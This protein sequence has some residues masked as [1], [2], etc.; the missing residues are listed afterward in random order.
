MC[1]KDKCR[2][3]FWSIGKGIL[4]RYGLTH[5]LTII[6][7]QAIRIFG[8]LFTDSTKVW[9]TSCVEPDTMCVLDDG[10]ETHMTQSFKREGP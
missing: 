2:P 7:D 3:L 4:L 1:I 9:A 5:V 10:P 6:H 8:I